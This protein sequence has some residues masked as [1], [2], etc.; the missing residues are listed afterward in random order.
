MTVDALYEAFMDIDEFGDPLEIKTP[1]AEDVF[2]FFGK[3]E[4]GGYDR[5]AWAKQYGSFLPTWDPSQVN[6]AIRE[7]DLDYRD[8]MNTL[9]TTKEATERVYATEM[10][11]LSTALGK[12]LGKGREIASRTGIRSGGLQSAIQDTVATTGS[13]AKDFGDRTRIA[14]KETKDKYNSAMVDSALDFEKTE[15]QEKEE[16]YDR[17]MAAI[18]RLMDTGAFDQI[19]PEGKFECPSDSGRPG[20]CV[21]SQEECDLL[22]TLTPIGEEIAIQDAITTCIQSGEWTQDQCEEYAGD[23]TQL[24]LHFGHG[25]IL[26]DDI[27]TLHDPLEDVGNTIAECLKIGACRTAAYPLCA[28]NIF[29]NTEDCVTRNCGKAC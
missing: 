24:V 6:L 1:F 11:T 5:E 2:K 21:D 17:T 7:R 10:D 18:M 12:E 20:V 3:Q 27:G 14:S 25:S 15:Q 4:L 23:T 22:G 28:A 29:T 16:F 13:K 26:P 8:A 9:T 19:C